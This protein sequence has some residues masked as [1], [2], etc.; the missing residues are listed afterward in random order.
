VRSPCLSVR[1]R[2]SA[3]TFVCVYA[4]TV[5]VRAPP[6]DCASLKRPRHATRCLASRRA[7]AGQV[8]T[9][10]PQPPPCAPLSTCE[11]VQWALFHCQLAH[12]APIVLFR[13]RSRESSSRTM[14]QGLMLQERIL[15]H[16]R[17]PWGIRRLLRALR[18]GEQPSLLRAR[19]SDHTKQGRERAGERKRGMTS[20]FS[21]FEPSRLCH[22]THSLRPAC[23][24]V[25][26][27]SNDDTLSLDPSLLHNQESHTHTTGAHT[28]TPTIQ[29]N[30]HTTHT[31]YNTHTHTHTHAHTKT[32]K[33][34]AHKSSII[35]CHPANNHKSQS[36]G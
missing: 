3:S 33:R 32:A 24:C 6:M 31:Q 15:P 13:N 2:L 14:R 27:Y 8:C 18:A 10:L 21:S 17:L 4:F 29:H 7:G 19:A 23:V 5:F 1:V 25:C 11:M 12:N 22:G 20:V 28:H 35:P 26:S 34:R 36:N 16:T 30:T 9:A